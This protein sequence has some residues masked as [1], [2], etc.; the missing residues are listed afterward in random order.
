MYIYIY[1]AMINANIFIRLH[2]CSSNSV[3]MYSFLKYKSV[4][5]WLLYSVNVINPQCL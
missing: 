4:L 5:Y 1:M 2:T 3:P